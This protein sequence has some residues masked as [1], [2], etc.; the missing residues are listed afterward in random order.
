LF[1]KTSNLSLL[2]DTKVTGSRVTE[3]EE[4]ELADE[5]EKYYVIREK[6]KIKPAFAIS[7]VGNVIC[8]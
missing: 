6:D 2:A 7:W 3:S 4:A 1:T 8:W 5:G